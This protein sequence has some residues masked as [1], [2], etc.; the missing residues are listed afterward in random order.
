MT[1]NLD[2]IKKLSQWTA[3]KYYERINQNT[4]EVKLTKPPVNPNYD[5]NVHANSMGSCSDPKTWTTYEKAEEF[6]SQNRDFTDGT[7]VVLANGLA[8]VDLDNVI[9]DGEVIPEAMEIVKALKSYTEYSP[10]ETGLHILLWIDETEGYT[11]HRKKAGFV[12]LSN[13]GMSEIEA[14]TQGRY[15]TVTGNPLPGYD[16]PIRTDKADALK[17]FKAVVERYFPKRNDTNE[18]KGGT[19]SLSVVTSIPEKDKSLWRKIFNSKKGKH[20]LSLFKNTIEYPSEK[21][22]SKS[23]VDLA[24]CS[25]LAYWTDCDAEAMDRMFRQTALYRDKWDE[26]HGSQTYGEMTIQKAIETNTDYKSKSEE[27]AV[28]TPHVWYDSLSAYHSAYKA[29][30][31]RGFEPYKTGIN[32]FDALIGGGLYPELYVLGAAT[33]SGKTSFVLQVGDYIARSGIP[34]LYTALEMSLDELIAKSISRLSYEIANSNEMYNGQGRSANQILWHHADTEAV[35]LATDRYFTEYAPHIAAL[36]GVGN[37]TTATI[38]IRAQQIAKATG[39][40]PV[41]I[42]DYLQLLAPVS[43]YSTEKQAADRNITA[44]KQLSRELTC[45]VFL[46]SSL[47]R[48]STKEGENVALESYKES[49]GIEY[50]AGVAFGMWNKKESGKIKTSITLLKH[51]HK[52]TKDSDIVYLEFQGEN[53]SFVPWRG[54]GVA[55]EVVE[56]VFEGDIPF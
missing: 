32:Q 46:I 49:G 45:P 14:Y 30:R 39:K 5:P 19:P 33:G 36:E 20:I 11:P 38:Q 53:S 40:A 43:P 17:D 26:M 34:V 4:G 56:Q 27:P 24:M 41:V 50:T 6:V 42:V 25:Y 37:I 2:D 8:G 31:E 1:N 48:T 9:V 29:N 3:W 28:I 52:G 51:R 18:P 55:S 16:I 47:N 44:L 21:Y 12:P 15:F 54:S 23:E 35:K 7:G 10:S 22:A 13:G